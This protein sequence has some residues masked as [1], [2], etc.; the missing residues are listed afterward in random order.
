MVIGNV[1]IDG[2]LALAPMAGVADAAFRSVCREQGAA[3]AVTEMISARALMY[4]DSKT[5]T[6]LARCDNDLPL[7]VQLFGREPKIMAD[8]VKKARDISGCEVIDINMGC[9]TGKIVR[10]GEGCALMRDLPLAEEIIRE[11]VKASDVPVTV[12]MRKGWDRGSV[13]A[14]ELARIA[15]REGAAAVA[16]HGR[17]G[18]QQYSGKADWDAIRQVK[19][20]VDIPVIANGDVFEPHDAVRILKVTGADLIFIGRGA[21]G[22][23][24]IFSRC[25]AALEGREPGAMPPPGERAETALRQFER[26]LKIKGEKITCLEA[27][28]HFAW[29]CRGVPYAGYVKAEISKIASMDDIYRI[30]DL[31]K[32]ELG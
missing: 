29:Y 23:P 31:I 4:Q 13:N 9:P 5:L 1:R 14:V 11:V 2:L 19:Q 10:N 8:A 21:M 17:T 27:R 24:W 3:Y 12:K 16:V 25:A 20:A 7:A 32:R 28:K 18:S 15:Q 30:A 22:D 26:A 6:L